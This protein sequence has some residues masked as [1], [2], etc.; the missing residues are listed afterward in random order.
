MVLA[1]LGARVLGARVLA[2]AVTWALVAVELVTVLAAL[3]D[4]ASVSERI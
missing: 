4:R 2:L 1:A 3:E